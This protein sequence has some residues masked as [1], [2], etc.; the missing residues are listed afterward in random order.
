MRVA[1]LSDIH[2]NLTALDAVLAATG[3]VDAVWHLGDVV[4]YGPDPDAV[5][6]RLATIG[7]QG[8]RGNHDAA[9][10]GELDVRDFNTDARRAVQWTA[11]TITTTTS[12]WLSALEPTRIEGDYTLVHG[13]PRDPTWEYVIGRETIEANLDA[14]TTPYGLHGHTHVPIAYAHTTRSRGRRGLGVVKP[15]DGDTLELPDGPVLLNP[16]SVGQPRDG[17]PTASWLQLDTAARRVTWRRVG[18]AIAELQERM[19]E[20]GL[21]DRLIERL[22][23]GW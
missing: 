9:V 7:A 11:A 15:A 22:A 14:L 3:E 2:A 20:R 12:D 17:I 5:V 13:S 18:Y 4:G 6:D 8:V 21:P 1:V 23:S 19:R 16:G 10:I